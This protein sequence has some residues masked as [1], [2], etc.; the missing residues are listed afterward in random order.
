MAVG[1]NPTTIR[2][3]GDC[4]SSYPSADMTHPPQQLFYVPGFTS[5]KRQDDLS[6]EDQ[7]RQFSEISEMQDKQA[8]QRD[9]EEYDRQRDMDYDDMEQCDRLRREHAEMQ[10]DDAY[11]HDD[12]YERQHNA[13]I[14][15]TNE[16]VD[17][18]SEI[19]RLQ[20]E[21]A[22]DLH[23][24]HMQMAASMVYVSDFQLMVEVQKKVMA[25][26]GDSQQQIKDLTEK[27]K[28]HNSRTS[29]LQKQINEVWQKCRDMEEK[30]DSK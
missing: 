27:I 6:E 16:V 8:K 30:L 7:Q 29:D 24:K 18:Q 10:Q 21:V 1:I 19:M 25:E 12:G 28:L 20:R 9:A 5:P 14:H 17:Y 23:T 3:L 11:M 13:M 2:A 22:S 15:L 26:L 4:S